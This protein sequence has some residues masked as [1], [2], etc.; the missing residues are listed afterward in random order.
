MYFWPLFFFEGNNYVYYKSR[1]LKQIQVQEMCF[2]ISL[3]PLIC[4]FVFQWLAGYVQSCLP[5]GN[6]W[7]CFSVQST[8][9]IKVQR[10]NLDRNIYN[11]QMFCVASLQPKSQQN[12]ARANECVTCRSARTAPPGVLA[13]WSWIVSWQV[14][15]NELGGQVCVYTFLGPK[16]LELE[17][18]TCFLAFLQGHI[19]IL[20]ACLYVFCL[21]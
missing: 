16:G 1:V 6:L 19:W 7:V 3:W 20:K 21:A 13:T 12:H 8:S 4:V 11:K 5:L 14:A 10:H 15:T 2:R 18:F 17:Y 9:S